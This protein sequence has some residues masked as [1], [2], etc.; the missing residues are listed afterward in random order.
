VT[1]LEEWSLLTGLAMARGRL[2]ML[3]EINLSFGKPLSLT[4]IRAL[5]AAL[6]FCPQLRVL[7]VSP[8][9]NSMQRIFMCS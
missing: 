8:N 4:A 5:S 6:R 3:L 2:P 7:G 1:R 9:R